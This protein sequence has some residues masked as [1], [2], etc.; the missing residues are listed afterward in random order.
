MPRDEKSELLSLS[1]QDFFLVKD[2]GLIFEL[3]PW[4]ARQH[5]EVGKGEIN[6]NNPPARCFMLV[7][8]HGLAA[9]PAV[10]WEEN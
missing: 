5:G 7:L 6:Q 8:Q 3:G 9:L 2:T 4:C 1:N 10:I